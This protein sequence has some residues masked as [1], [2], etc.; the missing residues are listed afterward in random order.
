MSRFLFLLI[1]L[2]LSFVL[3]ADLCYSATIEVSSVAELKTVFKTLN[4]GDSIKILPGTYNR[5]IYF[6]NLHGTANAPIIIF[7]SDPDNP[8]IFE[9]YGEGI[10]VVNSSYFKFKNLVFQ[11]S[12]KNGIN[13]S[14]GGK[15]E[16][17]SHH[18]VLE[19]ILVKNI[20]PKG[21]K[22]ALKLSGVD[23]FL[24]RN[25]HFEGWG[26]SGIDM[27][28]CHNG[29][30]EGN[31]FIR[32]EGYRTA[33]GI[34][35]KGGSRSILVQNN[36]FQNAGT[37]IVQIGGATG[38]KYFRPMETNYESKDIIVAGNTFIGGE[39]QVT[40][41]TAQ[42]SHVHHNLFYFP[43]KWV[44]RIQQETKNPRFKPSQRGFFEKN[45]IVTDNRVRVY[46][47]AS[48]GTAPESFIFRENLWFRPGG[49][50]KPI[51]P[52]FEKGGTYGVDPMILVK[53]DGS[54]M[55]NSANPQVLS[56]GPHAYIP[57]EYKKDFADV[58]IPQV[59]I[60]DQK[61]SIWERVKAL[62]D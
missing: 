57:W 9:T 38:L 23:H 4:P 10:K 16:E 13:I 19:N 34:Q 2:N 29:V 62:A 15:V 39:A 53:T 18:I 6:N 45:L 11:G 27:V 42:D 1:F 21:N 58:D 46:F 17:P 24:V 14:D 8:P 37:R 43:Q 56:V 49:N 51:L 7:G 32:K 22:D 30:I 31:S 3:N 36:F 28:G 33:N 20:G 47:N 5:G 60:P 52:T 35:M 44:G 25:S 41:V 59:I 55:I 48:K 40:W 12:S 26:G 54:S 61:F 50:S